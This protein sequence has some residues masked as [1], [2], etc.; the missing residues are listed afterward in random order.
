MTAIHKANIMKLGDGLF[1]ETARTVAA[2]YP[3]VGFDDLIVDAGCMHLVMHPDA[4]TYC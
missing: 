4:S 3:D 2:R 1:L